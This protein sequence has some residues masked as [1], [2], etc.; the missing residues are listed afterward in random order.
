MWSALQARRRGRADARAA[1]RRAAA[2][3]HGRPGPRPARE[4][5]GAPAR[6]QGTPRPPGEA[7][8]PSEGGRRPAAAGL[9]PGHAHVAEGARPGRGL[10]EVGRLLRL[11]GPLRGLRLRLAAAR[12]RRLLR[13]GADLLRP[14]H[15]LDFVA[16]FLRHGIPAPCGPVHGY[17]RAL[18]IQRAGGRGLECK[19]MLAYQG[20]HREIPSPHLRVLRARHG[21]P[22]S[23]VLPRGLSRSQISSVPSANDRELCAEDLTDQ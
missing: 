16:W 23:F 15:A 10:P 6:L 2:R 14:G 11:R 7:G 22:W 5:A 3:V 19:D 13:R 18:L 1:D 20:H 8:G 17:P 9:A 12:L 21:C 4:A